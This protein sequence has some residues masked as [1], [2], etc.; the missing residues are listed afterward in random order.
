M[1]Y[2]V[3]S[4]GHCEGETS[5]GNHDEEEEGEEREE[6]CAWR[7]RRRWRDTKFASFDTRSWGQAK[8]TI[9]RGNAKIYDIYI[10]TVHSP[11]HSCQY[12]KRNPE[13]NRADNRLQN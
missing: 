9:S 2:S 4:R 5:E 13:I 3:C 6:L 12:Y 8:Q 1:S 10:E 7:R 11:F